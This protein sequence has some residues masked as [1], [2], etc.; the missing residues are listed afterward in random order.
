V[1]LRVVALCLV[2]LIVC[3]VNGSMLRMWNE[4]SAEF[5]SN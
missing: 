2:H 4:F 3:V 5:S 1:N